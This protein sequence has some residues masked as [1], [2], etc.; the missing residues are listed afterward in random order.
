MKASETPVPRGSVSTKKRSFGEGDSGSPVQQVKKPKIKG[1]IFHPYQQ[2]QLPPAAQ[3]Q[4]QGLL[5]PQP[6][7]KA[8]PTRLKP[9][10]SSSRQQVQPQ[11]QPQPEP[12]Q[13]P[14]IDPNLFSMY[15]EHDESARYTDT[16]PSYPAEEQ[17]LGYGMRPGLYQLPSLEQIAN[18]VLVDLN[19]D[20][21]HEQDLKSQL[22]EFN[23]RMANGMPKA[24]TFPLP[25]GDAKPDESVDSAVSLPTSEV[26]E[27]NKVATVDTPEQPALPNGVP[28][29]NEISPAHPSIETDA[30]TRRPSKD[31]SSSGEEPSP[32]AMTSLP[33]YQPPAALTNSPETT[34]QQPLMTNGASPSPVESASLKRKRNSTSVT[35]SVKKARVE[36]VE[37]R[38]SREPSVPLTEEEK[39]SMELAKMLQ[40]EEL[41]LRRR[42]R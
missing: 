37:Q 12:E 21:N 10:P 4:G 5:K 20:D 1:E 27:Q 6:I 34:K 42:S 25:N 7:P 13:P 28:Q 22:I 17:P 39:Q 3:M 36:D 18:E 26:L 33:L 14:Q 40:Q 31:L 32:N 15:T 30:N 38:R 23:N 8:Q 11:P 24:D 9:S 41:G 29:E 16:R 2:I 35:P 19:G